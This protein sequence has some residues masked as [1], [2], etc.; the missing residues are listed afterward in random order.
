M[1]VV[2]KLSR[3]EMFMDITELCHIPAFKVML[4]MANPELCPEHKDLE[5]LFS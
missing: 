2:R 5:K 3:K 4:E 1:A